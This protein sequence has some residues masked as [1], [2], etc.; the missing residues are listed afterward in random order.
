MNFDIENNSNFRRDYVD[1]SSI[2]LMKTFVE[3][4]SRERRG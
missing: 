1:V 2:R 4:S 3:A